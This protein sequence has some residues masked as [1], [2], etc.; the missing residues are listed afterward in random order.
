ML[1]KLFNLLHKLLE[2]QFI[3]LY[4]YIKLLRVTVY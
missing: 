2:T 1:T 3:P 4:N